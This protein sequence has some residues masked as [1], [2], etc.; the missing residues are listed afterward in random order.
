M[1]MWSSCLYWERNKIGYDQSSS[2]TQTYSCRCN[3]W[4]V[5]WCNLFVLVSCGR[6]SGCCWKCLES[7]WS[8]K[9]MTCA[10]S[11]RRILVRLYC[12]CVSSFSAQ[13]WFLSLL[14][15]CCIN[16]VCYG[17][18]SGDALK[19]SDLARAIANKVPEV[20]KFLI[21]MTICNTVV[22]LKSA[23]GSQSKEEN[24]AEH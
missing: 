5:N 13:S 3:D 15:R 20:V 6:N 11:E 4:Q 10:I 9:E 21:V 22:P 17:N 12:H 1:D 19:N 2:R 18:E 14:R 16:G 8:M 7:L 24:V 23:S